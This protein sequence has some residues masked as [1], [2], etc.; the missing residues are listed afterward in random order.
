MTEIKPLLL[1]FRKCLADDARLPALI[2][3]EIQARDWS[4]VVLFRQHLLPPRM[5]STQTN[6]SQS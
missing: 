5:E 1:F 4:L 2:R 3:E 6:F